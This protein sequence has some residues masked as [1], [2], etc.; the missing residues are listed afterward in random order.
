MQREGRRMK[1]I[2][3]SA[4]KKYDI[5]ISSNILDR[6][7]KYAASVCSA[8]KIAIISDSN[9]WPIYGDKVINSLLNAGF[10]VCNYVFAAGE[11]R[12]NIANYSEIL[13]FLAENRL[14]RNDC[15]IAL[16]GGV[17]GDISGF[18]A[19]TYLRGISYIQVPTSLLA[20]VDSSVGGKTAIDL[21]AGKNL[22]GAFCQPDL[23][24]CDLDVLHTLPESVFRDGCA[25]VIKYSILFDHELFEHLEEYALNFDRS[26]V[27]SRCISLKRD[28]VEADEFEQNA[29][30]LLNLGHTIGHAIECLSKYTITHGYAVSAGMAIISKVSAVNGFCDITAKDRICNIL[31]KFLLPTDTEYGAQSLFSAA[32][33]DK[34]VASNSISLVT[35]SAIG[36]CEIRNIPICDFLSLIESGL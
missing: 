24:L 36:Q 6:I 11:E 23:V 26:Y 9:V 13:N 12:K 1:T 25:E 4:S 31:E 7:G 22:A 5:I 2:T 17:V 10:A 14:T 19:A 32:L 34:K 8:S 35:P 16:G 3:V 15:I 29:R 28:I 18:T 30:K 27:I 20:M 21:P 33:S